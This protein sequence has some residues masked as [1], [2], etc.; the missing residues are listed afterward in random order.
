[1]LGSTF[2]CVTH[3]GRTTGT[4]YETVAMVLAYKETG[5]AVISS[6]W[7]ARTDWMRNLRASPAANVTIG[8]R[9]FVPSERFLSDDESARSNVVPGRALT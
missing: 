4:R 1:M 5:E 8:A 9:S 3:V 6:A 2:L 7:G